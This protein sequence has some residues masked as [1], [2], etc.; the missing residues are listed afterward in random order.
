ML[1]EFLQAAANLT[2]YNLLF[3]GF[4]A[5]VF[6]G[7]LIGARKLA[8]NKSP[9]LLFVAL[10]VCIAFLAGI[11]HDGGSMGI[12]FTNPFS[13]MLCGALIGIGEALYRRLA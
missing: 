8:D 6:T 2:K 1:S 9:Y 5:L 7:V 3:V 11:V 4:I 10:W 12:L 13:I